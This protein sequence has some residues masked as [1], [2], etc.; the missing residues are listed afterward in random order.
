MFEIT[1]LSQAAYEG[2]LDVVQELVERNAEINAT[3]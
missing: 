2:Y 3:I 1:A